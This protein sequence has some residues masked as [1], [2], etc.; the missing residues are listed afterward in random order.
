MSAQ[1]FL[2]ID[3]GA[4]SGRGVLGSFDGTRVT[5]EEIGRF[6]TGARAITHADGTIRWD[7]DNLFSEAESLVALAR[8]RTGGAL[9]GVGIDS[10][11]VDFGLLDKSGRLIAPPVCYRDR[12]H[13]EAREAMLKQISAEEIWD[14]TGIQGMPFNTLYQL[15]AIAKR[16][17]KQLEAADRLLLIPDLIANRLTGGAHR[18]VEVSNGSTTQ[19]MS[20]G[21]TAW[22]TGLLERVG[23]PTHFLS[24]TVTPSTR[25]GETVGAVPVYAPATHDTAS[26]VAAAPVSGD[27]S[28]A[29]LSSGTW[30]LLGYELPSP[31]VDRTAMQAGFSNERGIDGTTRFLKN[32]MGLWLVQECRKCLKQIDGRDYSY[33][34]LTKL[35]AAAPTGSLV[36]AVNDRFLNPVD[37]VAEIRRACKDSGQA[38]PETAGELVRCCLESLALAYR[39]ACRQ[40]ESLLGRKIEVLHVIGGGSQNDLLNQ[41]TAD[42]CGIPVYAGPSEATALGNILAQ[43]I[44]AGIVKDWAEARQISRASSS[45]REFL[46]NAIE[47]ARWTHREEKVIERWNH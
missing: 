8:E 38:Q 7:I 28:W 30:S 32:I 6:P 31:V 34:E 26:A 37:M 47:H 44:G 25:I 2:A 39:R 12:S 23:L 4:E 40:I 16:D 17:P 43:M 19:M 15:A 41:W 29:F 33:E 24:P 18:S 22:N 10:W 20:P 13:G 11:G 35:A 14:A 3:L 21:A 27:R 5:L 45:V 9:A 46:P 1:I 42:A 36:D